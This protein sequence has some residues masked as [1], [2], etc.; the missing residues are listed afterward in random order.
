MVDIGHKDFQ[1]SI[2]PDRRKS[3]GIGGAGNIRRPSEIIYPPRVNNDGTRR[4]SSV[5][6]GM[7]TSSPNT[8]PD[9]KKKWSWFGRRNSSAGDEAVKFD[10]VDLSGDVHHQ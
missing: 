2:D 8:S 1:T 5:F 3:Y 4:R 6:S 7:T 9:G 10:E